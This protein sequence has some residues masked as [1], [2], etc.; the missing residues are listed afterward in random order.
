MF[1]FPHF[2]LFVQSYR[3]LVAGYELDVI[4]VIRSIAHGTHINTFATI[5]FTNDLHKSF[6]KT[7]YLFDDMVGGFA[8]I[9]IVFGI[10]LISIIR[11]PLLEASQQLQ[12][13]IVKCQIFAILDRFQIQDQQ[14]FFCGVHILIGSAVGISFLQPIKE[15]LGQGVVCLELVELLSL[16]HGFH[17]Q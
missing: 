11:T 17:R 9:A 13:A 10:M 14:L 6:C 1:L 3:L 15:G 12:Q 7:D 8:H 4:M 2:D 16:C 5:H